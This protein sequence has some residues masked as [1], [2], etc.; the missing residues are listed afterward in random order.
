M[1]HSFSDDSKQGIS[2]SVMGVEKL[3][4]LSHKLTKVE[5]NYLRAKKIC[6]SCRKAPFSSEHSKVCEERKKIYKTR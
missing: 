4:D 6:I 5:I 1:N 3:K 2:I